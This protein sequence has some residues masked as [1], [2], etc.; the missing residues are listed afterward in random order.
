MDRTHNNVHIYFKSSRD[1]TAAMQGDHQPMT[2]CFGEGGRLKH[3]RS[4]S[5]KAARG[6]LGDAFVR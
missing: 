2:F 6:E 5:A 1:G 3:V 4:G